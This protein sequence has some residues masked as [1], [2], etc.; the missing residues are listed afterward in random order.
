MNISKITSLLLLIVSVVHFSFGQTVSVRADSTK[1][2]IVK[3]SNIT[4]DLNALERENIESMNLKQQT[5]SNYSPKKADTTNLDIFS[6]SPI[7]KG[8]PKKKPAEKVPVVTTVL[9]KPAI[10]NKKADS[11]TVLPKVEIK[12]KITDSVKVNL[13]PSEPVKK[14]EKVLPVISKPEVKPKVVVNPRA[15]DSVKIAPKLDTLKKE[16]KVAIPKEVVKVKVEAKKQLSDSIK[17]PAAMIKDVKKEVKVVPVPATPVKSVQDD[18]ST[19][20][21]VKGKKSNPTEVAPVSSDVVPVKKF[22]ID[23][24]KNFKEFTFE[25]TPVVNKNASYSRRNEPLPKTKEQVEEEIPVNRKPNNTNLEKSNSFVSETYAQYNKEADSIRMANKRVLDSVMRSLKIKVPVVVSSADYIDI[26]VSGGGMI[27]NDDSKLYDHISVLHTG[28]I[29]RE[30]NTKTQGTQRIEKKISKDELTKLAQYIV[31]LDFMDMERDYDC[32]DTDKGCNERLSKS[33][34][35][36]PLEIT[37]TVGDKKNKVKVSFFAPR[38]E[39]NWVNYPVNLEK[40]MS[41]IFAIAER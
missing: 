13:K 29:Q 28:V 15:T 36:V 14:Q 34:Q 26:Y 40:I 16:T 4:K 21:V 2:T 6:T 39:K 18:F 5:P 12:Q 17:T 25:T 35:P 37:V 27:E 30:Y 23:T 24:T 38:L 11:L 1:K 8:A 33:P 10:V 3:S 19:Q 31:D 20:P 7:V 41:A 9:P 32:A 22:S